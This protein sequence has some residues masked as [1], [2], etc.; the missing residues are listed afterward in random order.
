MR[1]RKTGR[2]KSLAE[3]HLYIAVAK[4]DGLI[5]RD[6]QRLAPHYAAKSQD[7][8]DI[9]KINNTV[10]R[11]IKHDVMDLLSNPVYDQWSAHGHLEEAIT[12]LKKAKEAGDWGVQFTFHKNEKGLLQIAFLDGYV[13]KESALIKEIEKQVSEISG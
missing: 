9:M 12:S 4:A 11:R 3:A 7:V 1:D 5:S 13:I 6:E 8:F 2:M 10:R